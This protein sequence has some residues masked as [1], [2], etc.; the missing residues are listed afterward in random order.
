MGK[1]KILE[2]NVVS[3]IAAGEIIERPSSI[4]KEL[5][6]NSLDAGSDDIILTLDSAGEGSMLIQ[7][8]GC[9]MDGV[10]LDACAERH[11]T[12]KIKDDKDLSSIRTFGFRGEA[13]P[14]IASVSRMSITSSD[15][16]SGVGS[17]IRIT[18]GEKGKIGKKSHSLGT[19]ILVEGLFDNV[20]VRKKFMKSAATERRY[21]EEIAAGFALAYPAVSFQVKNKE[22]VIFNALKTDNREK[23]WK[24]VLGE[25]SFSNM[26][27]ILFSEKGVKITG[28]ISV[29][30][31]VRSD[32]SRIKF[33]VNRRPVVSNDLSFSLVKYYSDKIPKGT[34]PAAV[35]FIDVDPELV[36]V[37]VHPTKR[38]VKFRES[39]RV[40]SLLLKAY[41]TAFSGVSYQSSQAERGEKALFEPFAAKGG[42]AQGL[43][44]FQEDDESRSDASAAS[45]E[46]VGGEDAGDPGDQEFPFRI[47]GQIGAGYI[48]FEEKDG[49]GIVDQH[50]AHERILYER[51]KKKYE[52]RQTIAQ[53]L[54]VPEVVE[55]EK[56]DSGI[57]KES[58]EDL[59]ALGFA[60][61]EF[62]ERSF[63]IDAVPADLTALDMK[64]FLMRFVSFARKE[65]MVQDY[66]GME[67]V[68][69]LACRSAVMVGENLHAEEMFRILRELYRTENRFTCPHGRPI[70]KVLSWKELLAFFKR[71]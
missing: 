70:I 36:D 43:S 33:F 56:S 37:N 38:E 2:S 67:R 15:N 60:I 23:R 63:K 26:A 46:M 3:R 22:K 12:S 71:K 7:D 55:L 35:V 40:F 10:D 13:L 9:G 11:A 14:S 52:L 24:D 8:N 1:I 32:R 29:P 58:L 66:S 48:L 17:E 41:S 50:A 64:T 65:D 44:F 6:E 68:F 31:F 27:N 39:H 21:M 49:L 69:R 20:P 53:N 47:I 5:M 28:L 62:G 34:Y 16:D 59:H 19:T 18:Y 51:L 25:D 61:E 57:L 4:V 42:Y 54:L 30:T 45:G